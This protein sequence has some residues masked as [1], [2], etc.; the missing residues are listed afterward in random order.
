MGEM[1]TLRIIQQE[2]ERS[3]KI[4]EK[5]T[6]NNLKAIM[7]SGMKREKEYIKIILEGYELM[8]HMRLTDLGLKDGMC[9]KMSLEH[10][11][12]TEVITAKK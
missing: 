3:I 10:Q 7:S 5:L 12:K 8:G 1:L 11:Q 6:I 9:L 2:R 4:R